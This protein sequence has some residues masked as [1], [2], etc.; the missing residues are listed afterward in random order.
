MVVTTCEATRVEIE[1]V[2]GFPLDRIVV[3][4]LGPRSTGA[5]AAASV[6]EPF[7]LAVG[8]VT[9]RK[10]LSVLADAIAQLGPDCPPVLVAGPDGFF[11]GEVREDVAR[12]DVHGRFRFLG[13]VDDDRLDKL[14]ATATAVCHPSLAEGFGM[15][16]LEAMAHGAPVVAADL[17]SVREIAGDT[18]VLVPPDDANAFAGALEGL[19]AD[20]DGARQLGERARARSASY[21]WKGFTGAIVGAYE[22]AAESN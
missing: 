12:R 2:A 3:A 10:G 6:S 14:L 9:P 22:R 7:L 18:V 16:C 15:V 1:R 8:A 20:R 21:T 5:P 4:P 19:L 17:P 11:S 13:L